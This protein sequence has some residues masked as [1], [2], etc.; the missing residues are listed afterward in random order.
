MNNKNKESEQVATDECIDLDRIYDIACEPNILT[1]DEKKHLRSCEYCRKNLELAMLFQ[2]VMG[3]DAML[4]DENDESKKN[5]L[6]FPVHPP[7]AEDGQYS[8]LLLAGAPA[9][10]LTNFEMI[11]EA[12][13]VKKLHEDYWKAVLTVHLGKEYNIVSNGELIEQIQ[14]DFNVA[15]GNGSPLTGELK[16]FN[17][18]VN[19]R[20]GISISINN[21]N[22]KPDSICITKD[23]FIDWILHPV[24]KGECFFQRSDSVNPPIAGEL[25]L[26]DN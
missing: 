13:N 12:S 26:K 5:D 23:D 19:I 24:T 10:E 25:L 8:D 20:N 7:F 9:K 6:Q 16:I 2:N 1:E 17:K 14:I 18:T 3:S 21:G 22:T 11:Y 4:D 15:S